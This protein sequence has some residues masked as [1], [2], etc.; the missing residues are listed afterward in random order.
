MLDPLP[1]PTKI[2]GGESVATYSRRHAT[3]N[4]G[5]PALIEKALRERGLLPTRSTR[6]PQRQSIWRQLG[7]LH[8]RTFAGEG[9]AR[10]V[11]E[12]FLCLQCCHG[13]QV[14]GTAPQMGSL[15][16]RHKRWISGPRQMD[17]RN[18]PRALAAERHF[19]THLAARRIYVDGL[20]MRIGEEC[21]T[22]AMSP[23]CLT[24][25]VH[26]TGITA[27]AV[28]LYPEQVELARLFTRRA[29]LDVI[30][31]PDTAPEV[32]RRVVHET[33]T[34]IVPTH[35]DNQ[36]WRATSRALLIAERLSR[37]VQEQRLYGRRLGHPRHEILRWS[38]L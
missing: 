20:A 11:T 1:I 14:Y 21:C 24:E 29:F 36:P 37:I 32:R 27:P 19:R 6:S 33:V 26:T 15:C 38:T 2:Y 30:A 10:T 8:P 31:D 34:A 16:L 17:I 3:R 23:S 18:F 9:S 5:E 4:H 7:N 35:P 25:R 28:L 22:V 12:R 13:H